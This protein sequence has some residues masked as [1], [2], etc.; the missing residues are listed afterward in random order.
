MQTR[1]LNQVRRCAMIFL[2][3]LPMLNACSLT[4]A[5]ADR[6]N[7]LLIVSDDQQHDAMGCAGHPIVRT[8]NIDRLARTGVRF[9]RTFVPVPICTPSR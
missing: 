3:V 8:P 2:I 9:T 1:P 6:P 4:A 5:E 7:V